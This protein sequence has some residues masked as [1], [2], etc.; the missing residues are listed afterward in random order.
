[1]NII[2]VVNQKGGVG[3]TTTVHN[4][5]SQFAK[6]GKSVLLIDMDAQGSLTDACGLEPDALEYA[7]MD[8]FLGTCETKD[9][10][11]YFDDFDLVPANVGLS[12]MDIS[13][14]QMI[15]R[16]QILYNK[17]IKEIEKD[18]DIIL[19][20]C[21]PSLGIATINAMT[22]AN[23]IL[24]PVGAEYH[25]MKSLGLMYK[26]INLVK[27]NTNKDLQVLGIV[28]T[29][30][31]KRKMMNRK[32]FNELHKNCPDKIFETKI[33]SN[34]SLAESPAFG[35]DIHEYKEKSH[36]ALDYS[37]LSKEILK[38]L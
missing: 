32:I 33:R 24:I 12:Q 4:L 9:I 29:F 25:P 20:D 1:M 16:E 38:I 2:A 35:K 22:C 19:I 5:A 15:A 14:A 26:T 18:Y 28:L 8:V 34:I 3:K 10:M 11:H 6:S 36:G 21:P 31:D 7:L 17:V 37:N 30:F 13:L 27:Q 23:Y